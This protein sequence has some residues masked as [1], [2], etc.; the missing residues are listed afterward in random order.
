MSV[1]ADAQLN[2]LG[3]SL[4]KAASSAGESVAASAGEA[5]ANIAANK[6]CQKAVTYMDDHNKVMASDSE[7][8]KRLNALVDKNY[9]T[10][11]GTA[12]NYKVYDDEREANILGL[13][14]G[15]IRVYSGMMNLLNDD[16][17]RAVIAIQIGH[18]ANLDARNALL[19]IA[20]VENASNATAAQLDKMLTLSGDK[21]G[22]VINEL[23]QVP[24]TVDQSKAADTYASG[25]LNQNGVDNTVLPETLRKFAAIEEE[26]AA[27][28]G[29]DDAE[30]STAA[31][32]ITVNSGFAERISAIEAK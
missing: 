31:K 6:V 10:V 32:Y 15:S 8:S 23:I 25:L 3:K 1:P 4:G 16:E 30:L 21:F 20:G 14:D 22:S 5:S 9:T 18:I 28:A 26:D 19:K 29:D 13:A 2:K 24:Y 12:F 17:L 11:D 27:K 7:L